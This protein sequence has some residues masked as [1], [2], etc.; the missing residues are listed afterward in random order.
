MATPTYTL[1][2]STVLGSAAS[3]VTFSGISATGKGDLVLVAEQI[4]TAGYGQFNVRF[5]N[6]TVTEVEWVRMKGDGSSA[7]SGAFGGV[8]TFQG[9]A[10][11]TDTV[12]HILQLMD[13][14]AT[15]KQTTGLYR[16][17]GTL[18]GLH[19]SALRWLS[20]AAVTQIEVSTVSNPY[21]AGS[22]FHLYQIV[23]E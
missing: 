2:D 3:S 11:Q 8:T 22:T 12:L 4:V 23:S 17:N 21:E 18:Q 19:A 5:N 7:T 20:T 13:F 15:D 14:S 10:N 16:G 9:V 1:I 6:D